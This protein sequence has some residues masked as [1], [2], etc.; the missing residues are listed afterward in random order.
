[1][2]K[3]DAQHDRVLHVVI[4][5]TSLR[6]TLSVPNTNAQRAAKRVTIARIVRLLN[7]KHAGFLVIF[8]TIARL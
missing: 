1:M 7:V 8:R 4:E 6:C 2:M 5:R 3:S